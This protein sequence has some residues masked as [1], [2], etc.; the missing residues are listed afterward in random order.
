MITNRTQMNK[1]KFVKFNRDMLKL[2]TLPNGII[3]TIGLVI[4]VALVLCGIFIPN[5]LVIGLSLGVFVILLF[6][7]LL[8][9]PKMVEANAG[10]TFEANAKGLAVQE[11]EYVFDKD[12]LTIKNGSGRI[13]AEGEYQNIEQIVETSTDFYLVIEKKSCFGFIVDKNGFDCGDANELVNILKDAIPDYV[14]TF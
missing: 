12:G 11:F 8:L 9:F 2:R 4:G 14:T 7:L 13:L 3:G 10:K 6:T 5:L 1:E